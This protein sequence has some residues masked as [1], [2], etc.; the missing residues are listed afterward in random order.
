[1]YAEK[2]DK[3]YKQIGAENNRY[4][5]FVLAEIAWKDGDFLKAKSLYIGQQEHLGLL[6]DRLLLCCNEI[7]PFWQ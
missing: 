7:S 2:S 1:M 4:T 3:L 5:A 6:G